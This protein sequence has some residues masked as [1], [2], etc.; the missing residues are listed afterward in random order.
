MKNV[1]KIVTFVSLLAG[2]FTSKAQNT[3]QPF[4]YPTPP[5]SLETLYERTTFM[6]EHFWEKCN[7]KSIFSS[8][9]NFE[10]AFND[11]ISYMPYADSTV[12]F[13]SVNNLIKEVKKSAPNTITM[14]EIARAELY[15]DS[16]RILWDEL[17]IP[18]A[19]A[20][21]QANGL[22]KTTKDR[23]SKEITQLENSLLGHKLPSFSM[24]LPDG[25]VKNIDDIQ[26]SYILIFFD[27]PDDFSNTMARARLSSDY[28]L[29]GLIDSNYI[30]VI[31]LYA[32]VPD[33]TWK[34]RAESYPS[35]WIR[36]ASPEA[37]KL[38]DRRVTPTFF[39]ANK[40][41]RLLSKSL[42]AENLVEAF[43]SIINNQN[44]I[45]AE[46]ERLRQEAL[47]N[48]EQNNLNN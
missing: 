13:T 31:S 7:L 26:G 12:V 16:A 37:E 43:R 20:A 27:D 46:R 24:T 40:D 44:Q 35:N 41:H 21:S 3:E 34:E 6:V 42:D 29:N 19:R 23:Y 11:Y 22:D 5:E 8:R 17:Y 15:S 4:L 1:V 28:G 18:F 39:Y 14:G 45:K 2:C 48:R 38:F 25:S 33:E 10:R 36:A 32:G 9:K 30:T 47:K